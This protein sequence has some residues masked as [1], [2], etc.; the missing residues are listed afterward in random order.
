MRNIAGAKARG[1]RRFRQFLYKLFDLAD[2][3][4]SLRHVQQ[5]FWLLIALRVS[6]TAETNCCGSALPRIAGETDGAASVF[7]CGFRDSEAEAGSAGATRTRRIGAIEAL[8]YVGQVGGVDALAVILNTDFDGITAAVNA[9]FDERS[10]RTVLYCVEEKVAEDKRAV[11]GRERHDAGIWRERA[12]PD[13]YIANRGGRLKLSDGAGDALIETR[14]SLRQ[15]GHAGGRIGWRSG[16]AFEAGEGEH[17][18][19]EVF[20]ALGVG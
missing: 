2:S 9:K 13:L 6:E 12:G 5:R 11:I 10:Q 3:F 14:R 1:R 7:D 4:A 17:L 19:D 16:R 8:E 15:T 18:P 20:D